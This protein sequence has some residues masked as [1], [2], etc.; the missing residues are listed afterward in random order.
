MLSRVI[1]LKSNQKMGYFLNNLLAIAV[2]VVTMGSYFFIVSLALVWLCEWVNTAVGWDSLFLT[3]FRTVFICMLLILVFRK[4]NQQLINWMQQYHISVGTVFLIYIAAFAFFITWLHAFSGWFTLGQEMTNAD[5]VLKSQLAGAFSET[6]LKTRLTFL[7]WG[8]W[9][10]WIPW[11]TSLVVRTAFGFTLAR[12]FLHT[13][14]LPSVLFGWLLPNMIAEQIQMIA[15][16]LKNPVCQGVILLL[17]G[18]FIGCAWGKQY[19]MG[20]VARGMIPPIGKTS[21]RPLN[22]WM[23]V[24]TLWLACYVPSWFMLGWL[25][26]QILVTL[27]GIFMLVVVALFVAVWGSS[28]YHLW[29]L[30]KY[31]VQG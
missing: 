9:G 8:W 2:D 30:K 7:I 19:N 17:L 10:I 4:S 24:V 27:G 26:L 29:V 21:V 14:I 28:L 13:L 25:P 5:M 12:V 3:P 23:M 6:S 16:W 11:M 20:D 1:Q 22:R 18:S 31:T 15:D